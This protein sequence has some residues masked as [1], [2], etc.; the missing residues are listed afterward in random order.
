MAL[1]SAGAGCR[2]IFAGMATHPRHLQIADF[3]Y[4][5]PPERIAKFPLPQRD[6][7][8]LLVHRAGQNTAAAFTDLPT[9]L[10]PGACL[11]FNNSKVVEARLLFQKPSGGQIE[12]FVLEPAAQ[13]VSDGMQATGSMDCW[14]IVGGLAKWKGG[15][16]AQAVVANGVEV[17]VSADLLER[18][19]DLHLVRLRWQPAHWPFAELL[20]AVGQLPIPPYLQRPAESTDAERYQTVY[21]KADGSVAAPTAGLHFTPNVLQSLASVGVRQAWVTLHVGAGTFKPVKSAFIEGHTMHAEYIDVS[22]GCIAQLMAEPL[23]IPVGTTSMR[24]LESLYWMGVKAHLHPQ[25]TLLQL[26]MGQWEVYDHA[27]LVHASP[28]ADAALKALSGWMQ[29][30]GL[31]RLVCKTQI[32][33]APSYRFKICKGLITN[34]HQP[35]STLLLLVAALLGPGWKRAYEFALHNGFRFL[36]YGD[37]SLLL[38]TIES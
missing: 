14:C 19:P 8:R 29:A 35:Q 25:A 26:Q 9:H 22:A 4:H 11:V 16:L 20:H 6:G 34:F 10:P 18:G 17:V 12:I 1:S 23:V 7:S 32:L 13:S 30:R 38:P 5:L 31:Q 36:S 21:A 24:T 27:E 3:S 33:I 28:G 2:L 37:S 15:P